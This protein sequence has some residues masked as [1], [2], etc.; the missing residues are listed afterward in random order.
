MANNWTANWEGGNV[1]TSVNN[2]QWN[3]S[4]PTN[5]ASGFEDASGTA[6]FGGENQ[7]GGYS[8]GA[9]GGCFNCGEGNSSCLLLTTNMTN[10]SK[11]RDT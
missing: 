10:I 2:D 6:G 11:Q 7:D 9:S 5:G 4:G 1:T 8:G 3:E